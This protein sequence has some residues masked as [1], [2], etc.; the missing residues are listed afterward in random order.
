V[1]SETIGRKGKF[2]L[3]SG[4][5][6]GMP[7][8]GKGRGG[9]SHRR[10]VFEG[11]VNREVTRRMQEAAS[12]SLP[13][14]PKI[15]PFQI[16]VSERIF[17][18]IENAIIQTLFGILGGLVGGFVYGPFLAFLSIFVFAGVHRS[19]ALEGLTRRSA[20]ASWCGIVLVTI[21]GLIW[22]GEIVDQHRDHPDRVLNAIN[23][24]IEKGKSSVKH[25]HSAIPCGSNRP[26]SESRNLSEAEN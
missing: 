19:K 16:P 9:N 24:L 10:S 6:R 1:P 20:V 23:T 14:I 8:N 4:R 17:R 13:T 22:I 18:V 21:G 5:I 2:A 3:S 11:A 12:I 15:V 7:G 26:S 25:I